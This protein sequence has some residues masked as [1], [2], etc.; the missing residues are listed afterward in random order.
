MDI[1]MPDSGA[2]TQPGPASHHPHGHPCTDPAARRLL[3]CRCGVVSHL[4]CLDS[5]MQFG[6]TGLLHHWG[7]CTTAA[8]AA[9]AEA[10][11]AAAAVACGQ[12][13]ASTSAAAAE[14]AGSSSRC[15]DAPAGQVPFFG[16]DVELALQR[17]CDQQQ[18]PGGSAICMDLTQTDL[19]VPAETLDPVG[20]A[21][22]VCLSEIQGMAKVGEDQRYEFL[23]CE[24]KLN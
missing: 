18:Q 9:A 15:N 2:A 4:A 8:D 21:C 19:S 20:M 23:L 3:P 12:A 7:T 22:P 1:D 5:G 6:T 13:A 10:A 17:K 24:E 11:A 14:A 16:T